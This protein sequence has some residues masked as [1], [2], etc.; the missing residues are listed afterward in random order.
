MDLEKESGLNEVYFFQILEKTGQLYAERNN[1]RFNREVRFYDA[2][3]IPE[4]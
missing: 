1:P 2:S 4:K 3:E